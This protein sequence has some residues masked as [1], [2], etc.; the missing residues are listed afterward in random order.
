MGRSGT[1]GVLGWLTH[2]NACPTLTGVA[3]MPSPWKRTF[4]IGTCAVLVLA[5]SC[6]K[7]PTKPVPSAAGEVTPRPLEFGSVSVGRTSDL[8][9]AI[10]NTGG[11]TLTGTVGAGSGA[12]TVVSGN[13]SYSLMA[14]QVKQVTV[15]F[16]PIAFGAQQCV[17]PLGSS[18]CADLTCTGTS[19]AGPLWGMVFVPA[20]NFTMGSTTGG[21]FGEGVADEQPVHTVYL[22]AFYIDKYEVTNAQFTSFIYAG[23]YTTPAFWS[24]AGWSART[25]GGWTLP[26]YWNGAYHSG[27]AWPNFPVTGVSWYEAEAYANFT[28][29]RLPT[30]AEWEKAARGADQRTYPWGERLD[31]DRANYLGSGDPYEDDEDGS[32]PVGFYDGRLHPNPPFQTTDSPSPYGA[33]DMAGNVV[34]WVADW[35]QPDYYSASPVSNPP[36]PLTGSYRV[37]RG[38]AWGYGPEVH[39]QSAYRYGS[40]PLY[41]RNSRGNIGFRCARTLP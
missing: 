4:L 5:S 24:A 20:G 10:K 8:S 9:F 3:T 15:R 22:N 34:E 18:A 23:G 17:L 21:L 26:L 12:F 35:Y 14:G 1:R 27:P 16:A 41:G 25:L 32:T 39:L 2:G 36:G 19:P 13:G 6:S 37:M 40:D 7:T 33:Y 28:G 38:G 29:K 11:G 31:V 30:E